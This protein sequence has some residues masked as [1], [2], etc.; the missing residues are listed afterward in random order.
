MHCMPAPFVS[1]YMAYMHL[2][3]LWVMESFCLERD[4]SYYLDY[5]LQESCL[6]K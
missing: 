1:D 5:G 3:S 6:L 2:F 4:K